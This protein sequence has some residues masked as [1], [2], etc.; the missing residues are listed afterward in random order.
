MFQKV[1]STERVDVHVPTHRNK[2]G[3]RKVIKGDVI[4]EEFGNSNDISLVGGLPSGSNL[5]ACHS[6]NHIMVKATCLSEELLELVTPHNA[7]RL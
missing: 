4:M 1:I 7:V 6:R 2:L 3:T 5:H